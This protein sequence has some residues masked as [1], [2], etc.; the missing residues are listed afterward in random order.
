MLK[1]FITIN[2]LSTCE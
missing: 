2:K 1:V